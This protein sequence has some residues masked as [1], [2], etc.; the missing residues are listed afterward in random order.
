MSG[1]GRP[2]TQSIFSRFDKFWAGAT[3]CADGIDKSFYVYNQ[4]LSRVET[5]ESLLLV[6]RRLHRT[7]D[8]KRLLAILRVPRLQP[9]A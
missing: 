5:H 7:R 2:C 1:I 8:S 3:L 4:V 6:I 9:V